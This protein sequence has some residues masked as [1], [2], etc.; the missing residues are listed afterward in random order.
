L[1][2][3]SASGQDWQKDKAALAAIFAGK[4]A[5]KAFVLSKTDPLAKA[6]GN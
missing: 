1:P 5:A 4:I 3:A 2:L 6:S